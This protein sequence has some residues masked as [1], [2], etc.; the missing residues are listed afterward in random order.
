MA[1]P[2]LRMGLSLGIGHFR[3]ELGTVG[4]RK[5]RER[6]REIERAPSVWQIHKRKEKVAES[7]EA[8]LAQWLAMCRRRDKQEN[9]CGRAIAEDGG[10]VAQLATRV[11]Y[12]NA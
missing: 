5:K 2:R 4:L 1:A 10:T 3:E 8:A 6:E 11:R 12:P 9:A 7:I